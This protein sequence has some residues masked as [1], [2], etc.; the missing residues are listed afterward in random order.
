LSKG[1]IEKLVGFVG[2]K[3]KKGGFPKTFD[4]L[5]FWENLL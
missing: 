1:G 5:S 2:L 3:E 4:C